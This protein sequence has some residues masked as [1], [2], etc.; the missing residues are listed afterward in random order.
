M[1]RLRAFAFATWL[2]TGVLCDQEFINPPAFGRS[3]DYS[4]N[5]VYTEGS[6]VNIVWTAGELGKKCS[7]VLY[8][9]NETDGQTVGDWEF[10]TRDA[11]DVTSYSWLVGTGKN[12]S[13]SNLFF[14][15]YYQE[16]K[17]VSNMNSHYFNLEAKDTKDQSSSS[18]STSLSATSSATLSASSTASPSISTSI[19]KPTTSSSVTSNPTSE[20]T[21]TSSSDSKSSTSLR[22]SDGFTMGALIGVGVGILVM[23]ILCV[24][25]G[26]FWLRRRK[27]RRNV[28]NVL[29]PSPKTD[30][31]QNNG[32]YYGSNLNEAPPRSPA[33]MG[34]DWGSYAAHHDRQARQAR[35]MSAEPVRYEM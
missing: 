28:V 22:S 20:P 4:R 5:P 18:S 27:R 6:T 3:L 14:F 33:E 1:S 15:S 30:Y 13:E 25:A 19:S 17:F 11:V 24:G 2:L 12:L 31:R 21:S 35:E 16:E 23:I 29:P 26:F 7:L 10:L 9:L 34:Q 32:S 8:Q